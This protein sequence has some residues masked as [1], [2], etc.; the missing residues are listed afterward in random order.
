MIDL[1]REKHSFHQDGLTLIERAAAAVPTPAEKGA[2]LMDID[3]NMI[4]SII[5]LTILA[6]MIK[7]IKK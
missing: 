2:L 7:N 6:D 4:I 1:F 5:I 3:I